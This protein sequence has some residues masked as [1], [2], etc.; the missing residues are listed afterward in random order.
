MSFEKSF[1][2]TGGVG[3]VG[4]NVC[5]STG[6]CAEG[7]DET[8]SVISAIGLPPSGTRVSSTGIEGGIE[9]IEPL[10]L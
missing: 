4:G 10:A 7:G 3:I 6:G 8:V 9:A 5:S 1:S 2:G